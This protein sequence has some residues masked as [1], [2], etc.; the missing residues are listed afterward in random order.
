VGLYPGGSQPLQG[1]INNT[2]IALNLAKMMDIDLDMARDELFVDALSLFPDSKISEDKTG[3]IFETGN[4]KV[5]VNKNILIDGDNT[6]SAKGISVFISEI[7][8]FF[9]PGEMVRVIKGA[10]QDNN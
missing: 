6:I 5:P 3:K 9:I 10:K 4:F 2:D 1:N 8:K 7:N